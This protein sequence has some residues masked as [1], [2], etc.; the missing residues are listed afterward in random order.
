MNA[1]LKVNMRSEKIRNIFELRYALLAHP[2]WEPPA[3]RMSEHI[4]RTDTAISTGGS[5]AVWKS[6]LP[7]AAFPIP[8]RRLPASEARNSEARRAE[9][10]C[11][12]SLVP[13]HLIDDWDDLTMTV[14]H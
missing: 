4:A 12:R 11:P 2:C 13:T 9:L 5:A 1:I 8:T 7:E 3:H 6:S 14:D 10:R